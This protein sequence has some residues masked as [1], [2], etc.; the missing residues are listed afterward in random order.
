MDGKSTPVFFDGRLFWTSHIVL[1]VCSHADNREQKFYCLPP[2]TSKRCTPLLAS[3]NTFLSYLEWPHAR[4]TWFLEGKQFL[5]N[6][7]YT[8]TRRCHMCNE[9]RLQG[10]KFEQAKYLVAST[11]V[12]MG[13]TVAWCHHII[14]QSHS[15]AHRR[16]LEKVKYSKIFK[17]HEQPERAVG[18][19]FSL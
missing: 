8:T 12:P 10:T 15:L 5:Q 17:C 7:K 2:G 9:C 18:K 4:Q 11:W 13:A 16:V 6:T 14:T 3:Q 19:Q 1:S